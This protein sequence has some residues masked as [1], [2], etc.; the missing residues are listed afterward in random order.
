MPDNYHTDANLPA[1]KMCQKPWPQTWSSRNDKFKSIHTKLACHFSI[2]PAAD[3]SGCRVVA[4]HPLS[5]C[6]VSM[7]DDSRSI[8]HCPNYLFIVSSINMPSQCQ[9]NFLQSSR[10]DVKN[11]GPFF[12][13]RF[14]HILWQIFSEENL[15]SPLYSA[16]PILSLTLATWCDLQMHHPLDPLDRASWQTNAINT[17]FDWSV[18]TLNNCAENLV[19]LTWKIGKGNAI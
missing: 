14:S 3:S 12:L 19:W 5:N 1:I 16:I 9:V 6:W 13:D 2:C 18:P 11:S 10:I 17:L 4:P 8:V 7:A 15:N